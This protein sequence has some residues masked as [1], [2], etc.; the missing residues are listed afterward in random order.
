QGSSSVGSD[1][2]SMSRA[3]ERGDTDK[4]AT[5]LANYAARA[6]YGIKDASVRSQILERAVL[7]LKERF[8]A[9]SLMS[10]PEDDSGADEDHFLG[11]VPH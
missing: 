2:E 3:I 10:Q 11:D 1:V 5:F 4:A 9:D 7:E 8:G 6:L